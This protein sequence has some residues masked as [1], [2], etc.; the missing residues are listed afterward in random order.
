ACMGDLSRA[1][2]G[3]HFKHRT[4]PSVSMIGLNGADGVGDNGQP[5]AEHLCRSAL[6][7]MTF[8]VT[9]HW[10]GIEKDILLRFRSVRPE[11]RT[12]VPAQRIGRR[13]ACKQQRANHTAHCHG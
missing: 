13:C 7:R 4:L 8:T 6:R 12:D 10:S 2:V 11:Y 5:N 9:T 1:P 3:R